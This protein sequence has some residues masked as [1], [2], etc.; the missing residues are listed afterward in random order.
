MYAT[1][2]KALV[3]FSVIIVFGFDGMRCKRNSSGE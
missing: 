3:L 2:K 1:G